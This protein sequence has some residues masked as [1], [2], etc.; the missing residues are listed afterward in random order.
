MNEDLR[1]KEILSTKLRL[2]SR[3]RPQQ[4]IDT[5]SFNIVNNNIS[6]S[7]WRTAYTVCGV[8]GHSREDLYNWIKTV[9]D[10]AYQMIKKYHKSTNTV[11]RLICTNLQLDIEHAKINII[12]GIRETYISDQSYVIRLEQLADSIDTKLKSLTAID[13]D[14]SEILRNV[15]IDILQT[16]ALPLYVPSKDNSP[17]KHHLGNTPT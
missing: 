7:F 2:I 1:L 16:Y 9:T 5:M 12:S 15:S 8:K 6:T 10:E 13:V 4:K 17:P 3:I 14:T 11:D